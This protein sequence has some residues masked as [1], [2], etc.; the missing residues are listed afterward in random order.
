MKKTIAI[1]AAAM[2]MLVAAAAVASE[3]WRGDN[4]LAGSVVDK[5]TGAPIKGA[6]LSL[7]IQKGSNGGP[8]ITSDAGG[9]WAVLGLASGSWNI[10]VVAPGYVVRQI[11]P[12]SFQE[13]Q[14]LPPVKIEL[15]P[16]V[17]AAPA[18]NPAEARPSERP[19]RPR[20]D[21]SKVSGTRPREA[22]SVGLG[23]ARRSAP[24]PTLPTPRRGSPSASPSTPL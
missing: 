5:K 19:A 20:D 8:D 23:L 12:V 15:E 13:G 17:A 22:L 9:K 6:K 11:G 16:Q 24:L 3:D 21:L 14:R 7:R 2:L 1:I 18:A 4:R 10:D